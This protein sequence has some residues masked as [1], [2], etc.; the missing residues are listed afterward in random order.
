MTSHL[1]IEF[2][3]FG[4]YDSRVS[5]YSKQAEIHKSVL[6]RDGAYIKMKDAVGVVTTFDLLRYARKFVWVGYKGDV[7]L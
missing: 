5:G 7:P 2:R 3:M 1:K 4:D 6:E